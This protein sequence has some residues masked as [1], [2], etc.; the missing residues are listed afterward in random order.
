MSDKERMDYVLGRKGSK[1]AKLDWALSGKIYF[2]DFESNAQDWVIGY[3]SDF[4][5]AGIWELGI[6]IAT[7][8]D[9]NQAQPGYDHSESGEQCFITGASTSPGSVGFDDVDGGKTTLLSP[10]YE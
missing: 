8:F 1:W 5:S 7:S 6:P 9:G 4:A 2:N 10:I 3:P